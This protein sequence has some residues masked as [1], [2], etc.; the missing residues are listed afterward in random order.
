MFFNV[1]DGETDVV[2]CFDLICM[3]VNTWNGK[4]NMTIAEYINAGKVEY[5]GL[6]KVQN[7]LETHLARVQ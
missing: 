6:L 7:T 4:N 3:A 2:G 1:I 5:V